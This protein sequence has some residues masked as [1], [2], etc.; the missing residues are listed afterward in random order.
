VLAQPRIAA[1]ATL[2]V[3]NFTMASIAKILICHDSPHWVSDDPF[4]F[5]K[6]AP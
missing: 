6:N 2:A 5:L 3:L 1:L 4:N